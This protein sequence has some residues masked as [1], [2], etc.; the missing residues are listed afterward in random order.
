MTY[1]RGDLVSPRRQSQWGDA[2]DIPFS[3]QMSPVLLK[4]VTPESALALL[5]MHRVLE[6]VI[7]NV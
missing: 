4:L 1:S 2:V 7:V 5:G 3:N 6:G